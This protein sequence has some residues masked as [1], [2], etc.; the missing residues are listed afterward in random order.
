MAAVRIELYDDAV[1]I[2]PAFDLEFLF[3][4]DLSGRRRYVKTYS[5][6]LRLQYIITLDHTRL[7]RYV[8]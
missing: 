1:D 4:R 5:C 6:A 2:R 8:P 3:S 7:I